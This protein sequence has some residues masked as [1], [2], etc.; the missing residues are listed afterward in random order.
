MFP[1]PSSRIK[2]VFSISS[3]LQRSL[4][5]A[6]RET[7][8]FTTTFSLYCEIYAQHHLGKRNRVEY[9]TAV[10]VLD[11]K[12]SFYRYRESKLFLPFRLYLHR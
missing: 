9:L 11:R 7:G 5:T 3:L 12:V 4:P 8:P 1:A 2:S 10:G 6:Q